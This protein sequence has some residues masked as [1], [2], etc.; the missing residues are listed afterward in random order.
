MFPSARVALERL[1]QV[2]WSALGHALGPAADLPEL[3]RRAAARDPEVHRRA[4]GELMQRLGPHPSHAP[5]EDAALHAVPYLAALVADPTIRARP[6]LVELLAELAVGDTGPHLHHGLDAAALGGEGPRRGRFDA[7]VAHVGAFRRG[8]AVGDQPLRQVM[9]YLLA[10]MTPRAAEVAPALTR[11]LQGDASPAVRASAAL[12]LSL[13][14]SFDP[15]GALPTRFAL[16]EAWG[17]AATRLERRCVG[18]ALVRTGDPAAAPVVDALIDELRAGPRPVAP[19]GFPWIRVD[20]AA[21][22][23]CALTLA[24]GDDRAAEVA[25]A[26]T[27]GLHRCGDPDDAVELARWLVIAQVPADTDVAAMPPLARRI[28]RDVASSDLVWHYPDAGDALADKGLPGRRDALRA[29][30]A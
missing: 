16:R 26:A 19:S 5:E 11:L 17:R 14:T 30:L 21:H 25:A 22:L 1:D 6:R 29:A 15:A 4:V 10:W 20:A 23:F 8:L 9:P 7:V 28:L 13:V 2:D 3:V 27:D 18:L 24:V 12:G